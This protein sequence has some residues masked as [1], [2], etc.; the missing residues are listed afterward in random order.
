MALHN[1]L[2]NAGLQDSLQNWFDFPIPST[3]HPKGLID[4]FLEEL[5]IK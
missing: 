4:S 3:S 5:A 1:Y 2:N